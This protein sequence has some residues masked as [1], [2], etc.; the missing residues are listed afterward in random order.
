MNF[1]PLRLQ[2]ILQI[3]KPKPNNAVS[4][5][6]KLVFVFNILVHNIQQVGRDGSVSIATRY[7][8]DGPGIES[9]WGQN[10]PHPCP[11]ALGPTQPSAQRVP[12][13]FPGGKAA[14]AWRWSINPPSAEIKERVEVSRSVPF[15]PVV[16]WN[17]QNVTFT[18]KE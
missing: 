2:I 17:L 15:W 5:K 13:L 18:L 9:R 16:R 7:G 8:W 10:F 12:R 4:E 1:P 3:T 6:K 11:P 14:E